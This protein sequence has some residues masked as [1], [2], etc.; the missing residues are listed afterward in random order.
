LILRETYL[1]FFKEQRERERRERA[2]ERR[3]KRREKRR[4][5]PKVLV[6]PFI[7]VLETDPSK[8]ALVIYKSIVISIRSL[9]S[10][11]P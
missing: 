6:P 4:G 1:V 8:I 11:L 3:E 9:F 10:Y 5:G 7:R 2:R